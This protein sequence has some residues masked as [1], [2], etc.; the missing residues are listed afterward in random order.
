MNAVWLS[1]TYYMDPAVQS[2]SMNAERLLTRG[3]ALAGAAGHEG[4]LPF[5]LLKFVGIDRAEIRARELVDAGL[6]I[7]GID[8]WE[9]RDQRPAKRAHIPIR[10]RAFVFDRDD[11]QCVFCG[12][13]EDLALDHIYPWSRGGDDTVDNLQTLCRSCNSRKGARI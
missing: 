13:A 5:E 10:V 12:S 4:F 9:F 6:W 1:S 2:L 8:G 3:Y 7:T 11:H